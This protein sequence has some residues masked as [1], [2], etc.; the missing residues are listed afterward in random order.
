MDELRQLSRDLE[1]HDEH[2]T[3]L[4][5]S[6]KQAI[7]VAVEAFNNATDAFRESQ[8][9]Q[10]RML[11]RTVLALIVLAIGRAGLDLF[12]RGAFK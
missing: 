10:A 8:R 2:S 9:E 11:N 1:R 6:T 3:E 7:G 12:L 4:T 5:A